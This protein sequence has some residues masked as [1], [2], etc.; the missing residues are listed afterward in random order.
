MYIYMCVCVCVC[1][2]VYTHTHTHTH[3]DI[4]PLCQLSSKR[5]E[6]NWHSGLLSN[7]LAF[8]RYSF[9][10]RLLGFRVNSG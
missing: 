9:A 7:E 2:C 4:R 1:V 3:E 8:T 6:D 5:L 10:S